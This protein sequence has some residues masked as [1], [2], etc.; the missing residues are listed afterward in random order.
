[1]LFRS[2]QK[3][4]RKLNEL[5]VSKYI[6][7]ILYAISYCHR[8]NIS[9]R[10][11]KLENILIDKDKKTIKIIDFGF[12]VTVGP[13]DK[14]KTYCGTPSY[15]SPEIVNKKEYA[16]PP[17][18]IWSIGIVMY[19]LICGLHPFIAD[20]EKELYKKISR[21]VFEYPS[22]ISKQAKNLIDKML[23]V[24][25]NKR[26]TADEAL[27]DEFFNMIKATKHLDTY[28]EMIYKKLQDKYGKCIVDRIVIVY[29]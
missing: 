28:S 14:L 9:H 1:M 7:E 23:Q 3:E 11:M 13:N 19:T 24:N 18:D 16:G 15:M 22:Y 21:G 4:N 29:T 6:K 17:S 2:R 8:H 10:D 25:P 27:N 20:T 26:I 12:A 5:E